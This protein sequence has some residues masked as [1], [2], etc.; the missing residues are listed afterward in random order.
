VG[1]VGS[2][3][4]WHGLPTLV[5]AFAL[6]QGRHPDARLRVVGEGPEGPRLLE[7]LSRRGLSGAAELTG[8]VPPGDV[9]GLLAGMDA[10]VAPYPRLKRFYFSPLKV[11]EYMASGLPVVASRVGQL[12]GLIDDR[13][14][15]LLCPPGDATALAAEL[16]EL[17]GDAGLR[18][19]LG[20]AARA[21]VVRDHTWEAVARR[22]LRLAA[23]GGRGVS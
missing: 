4:P 2:L 9:P 14:N 19:R 10:A 15:G 3:K 20:A 22:L 5:E 7:D 1:F 23:A 16:E 6:L 12:D 8:A 18:R 11:Y 17:R 21:A 13:V